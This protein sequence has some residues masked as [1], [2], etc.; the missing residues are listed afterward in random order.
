[1]CCQANELCNFFTGACEATVCS[2]RICGS[3][4]TPQLGCADPGQ[5]CPP[6][7]VNMCG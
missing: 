4:G 5:P 6:N 2:E 7:T 1:V 3:P